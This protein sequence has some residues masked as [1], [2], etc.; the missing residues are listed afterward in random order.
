MQTQIARQQRYAMQI[1]NSYDE[2]LGHTTIILDPAP[3]LEALKRQIINVLE[4]VWIGD[5]LYD[6]DVEAYRDALEEFGVDLDQELRTRGLD[7]PF[8]EKKD[9]LVKDRGDIGEVLG[10]LRETLVRGISATDIFV[11][12]I[13]AKLKGGV[14]THGL[15]GI[16]F[17][18]G[19]N[20]GS[21]QMT[22]CEW[23]HTLVSQSLQ[24]PCSRASEEWTG[25]T[26][27]KLMQELRRVSRMYRHR[28]DLVRA[29]SLKWFAYRWL[30]KD[31]CV[32]CVTM[33]VHPDDLS[34]DGA[35]GDISTHLVK[36]CAEHPSNPIEPRMHEG[37]LLPVP[38]LGT[39][40]DRCYQEFVVGRG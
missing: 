29:R 4:Q 9:R 19:D 17:I 28:S 36:K 1:A 26:Y 13:W 40:L 16:G 32:S 30:Q 12:L 22:L 38:D 5:I 39:F 2:A 3:D 10:Y 18:W 14:T 20:G 35:R 15:D 34:V 7:D 27:R 8:S 24:G 6:E 33:I 31:S 21:D 37:N 11:P 25:L 23:K